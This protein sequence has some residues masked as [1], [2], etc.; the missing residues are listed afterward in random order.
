MNPIGGLT[1]YS[2]EGFRA[3]GVELSFLKCSSREYR[4]F[5]ETFVPA[6]SIL[7]VMMFNSQED[8]GN[9]LKEYELLD[10]NESPVSAAFSLA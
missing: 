1:L 8:I 5:N 9:M 10:G 2:G 7:D 4:Q 3:A 6:L